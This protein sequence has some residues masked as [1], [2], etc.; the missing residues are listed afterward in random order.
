[1]SR[2]ELHEKMLVALSEPVSDD[3]L[4]ALDALWRSQMRMSVRTAGE[5]AKA[6]EYRR[7]ETVDFIQNIG[8]LS[9]EERPFIEVCKQ[10]GLQAAAV[11]DFERAI[12]YFQACVDRAAMVGERRTELSAGAMAYLQ[13]ADIDR[14]LESLARKADF[15]APRFGASS[16]PLKMAVL[17][18]ALIDNNAPSMVSLGYATGMRALGYDVTVISTEYGKSSGSE[19]LARH[20]ALG[21]SA[22]L[23]GAGNFLDRFRTAAD[24][25]VA[26]KFDVILWVIT[27]A[28]VLGRILGCL[29][30]AKAQIYAN[31]ACEPNVGEFDAVLAR[32]S[33]RQEIYTSWPG[34]SRFTGNFIT[35]RDE[36][37]AASPFDR[38]NL[39]VQSNAQIIGTFGRVEKCLPKVFTSALITVLTEH[40]RAELL[41]VGPGIPGDI[42]RLKCV[43]GAAGVVDRVHFLGPM[44]ND[45]PALYKA[46]DIYC[47]NSGG[48]TVIEAMWAG[49]PVVGWAGPIDEML[50]K[51]KPPDET[52]KPLG[53]DAFTGSLDWIAKNDDPAEYAGLVLSLLRDKD[54]RQEIADSV[55]E[56]ARKMHDPAI[57][58][59]RV[60]E[61][62]RE[63]ISAKDAKRE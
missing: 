21:I 26:Q 54:L 44:Q 56:R 38:R 18:S 27:P 23:L 9:G 34:K 8:R 60:D 32:G 24:W 25:L 48:Q 20:K 16:N 39:P 14:A 2:D 29:R 11:N 50:L 55:K 36:I 12:T 43:F 53:A 33:A 7:Q 5:L 4:V 37:D 63:I 13:D 35:I 19:N 40:K 57:S 31:I 58:M 45:L 42:D 46:L 49:V 41:I 51:L 10:L 28:D 62:I 1:M 6:E 61:L 52:V 59:Q 30:M 17:V 47:D 22:V 3:K 15:R